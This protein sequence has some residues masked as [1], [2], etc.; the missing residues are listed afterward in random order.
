[1]VRSKGETPRVEAD[2]LNNPKR[3]RFRVIPV[4]VGET[5]PHKKP[6]LGWG[7]NPVWWSGEIPAP[8]KTLI[9]QGWEKSCLADTLGYRRKLHIT[10]QDW[11]LNLPKYTP[12]RLGW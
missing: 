7:S 9:T 11:G 10:M 5:P 6:T 3:L 8:A 2:T 12:L 1:M 4:V